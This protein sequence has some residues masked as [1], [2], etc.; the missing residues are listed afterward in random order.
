[1]KQI[2]HARQTAMYLAR[3]HTQASFPEIGK[4]FNKDHS[5]AIAAVRKIET[6]LKDNAPLRKEIAE[7][8]QK[9]GVN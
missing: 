6:L 8:E 5:T 1:M 7:I 3:K 2:S 9:L 4:K